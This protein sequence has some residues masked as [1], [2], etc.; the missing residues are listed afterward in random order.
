MNAVDFVLWAS[1]N[2][3]KSDYNTK[4]IGQA[5]ADGRA[6][7]VWEI[8]VK[9]TDSVHYRFL[10]ASSLQGSNYN[11][12]SGSFQSLL[13]ATAIMTS[14]IKFPSSFTRTRKKF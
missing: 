13:T 2:S 8:S 5:D 3:A 14:R 1:Y 9:K 11:L 12:L 6:L 4:S 10:F 7:I